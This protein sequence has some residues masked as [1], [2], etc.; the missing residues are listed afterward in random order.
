M[1]DILL[2]RV[3]RLQTE[4]DETVQSI[5]AH[6]ESDA[7]RYP[8]FIK[9]LMSFTAVARSWNNQ[10][11]GRLRGMF[12][13][14]LAEDLSADAHAIRAMGSSFQKLSGSDRQEFLQLF[15]SSVGDFLERSF[16]SDLLKGAL[17]LDGVLGQSAGAF[18]PGTAWSLVNQWTGFRPGKTTGTDLPLGGMGGLLG[19]YLGLVIA[20][21]WYLPELSW[22]DTVLIAVPANLLGQTGD[23]CESLIKRSV[24]V[25]DSGALLPGHGGMLDILDSLLL[26]A[27]VFYLYLKIFH[28]APAIQPIL[29][30]LPLP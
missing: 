1:P 29:D 24:D 25:K 22:L 19:S 8:A 14:G 26:C 11:P 10:T 30:S 13:T 9:Q 17:A 27:P 18:T 15:V 16:E 3:L 7:D 12:E 20:K 5:R 23:L 28:S 6:S 21:L 2:Y 4:I